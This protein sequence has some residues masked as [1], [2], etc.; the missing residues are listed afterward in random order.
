MSDFQQ[1]PTYADPV[2]VDE[3]TGKSKFNPI[4]LKWFLDLIGVINASGGGGGAVAHNDTTGKQG[5]GGTEFFHLTAAQNTLVSGISTTA[6]KINTL[7]SGLTVVITTAKL[8]A[9]GANGSMTF[10]NGVLTAQTPAT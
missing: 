8:T 9:G 10:T 5:G 1:P 7:G 2:V 3:P 6:A 4:W